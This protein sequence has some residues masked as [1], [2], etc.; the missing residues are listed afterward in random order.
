M[1]DVALYLALA[2]L[3]AS[4]AAQDATLPTWMAGCWE[5]REGE[6]WA[7]ECW[8]IPRAGMMM[9]SGRTGTANAV[10]SW[11][12]MRIALDEP[13]GDGPPVRMAF[14]ASPGGQG[15]TI[16]AAA[17]DPGAGVTFVNAANDFPQRVRY[18]RE[19]E[20]LKAEISLEDGSRAMG[21][22]FTRMGGG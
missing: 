22:T 5:M 7:E 6:N 4:A 11:E 15:W 20:L 13:N 12:F 16:F 2:M 10:R 21:W 19:G 17:S 9:G 3:P 14:A 18:W 8:T 1:R